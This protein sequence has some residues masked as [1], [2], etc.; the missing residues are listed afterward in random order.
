MWG[1]Y[2]RRGKVFIPTQFKAEAGFYVSGEP[3]FVSDL[4][5]LESTARS[6]A[7]ILSRGCVTI[8]TPPVSKLE[9]WVVLRHAG[10][11]SP[12]AFEK[13]ASCWTVQKDRATYRFGPVKKIYP[14]GWETEPEKPYLLSGNL[15]ISDVAEEIARKILD[16]EKV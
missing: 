6:I 8:P 7:Q 2:V 4:S 9:K 16:T 14:R 3:V 15:N 12:A 1:I 10:V 11:S 5:D 13:G